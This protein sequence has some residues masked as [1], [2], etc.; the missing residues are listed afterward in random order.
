MIYKIKT[1][2][3]SS[4]VATIDDDFIKCIDYFKAHGIDLILDIEKTE[5]IKSDV[6]LKL[7]TP[8]SME[9]N[10][11]CVAYLYNRGTFQDISFGLAFNV[12]PTLRGIYLATD[13]VNDA[14]D[15]TWKSLCHEIVHTFF[16]KFRIPIL[17]PMDRML[18]N[19][20]WKPYYKDEE[21]KPDGWNAPDGNFA[22][23]WK[24]LAPYILE[25]KPVL[26]LR[27]IT[28]DGVQ[29]LGELI[30]NDFKCKTLEKPWKDNQSNISCVP[31]GLYDVKWS[32]FPRKLRYAY[33]LQNVFKR[34]GIF[35]H[36]GNFFFD[37]KG[38]I[39]LGMYYVDINKDGRKDIINSKVSIAK[40]EALMGKKPFKLK[41]I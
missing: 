41:I 39:L 12:S 23:A 22:E 31:K 3:H 15:F 16:Y 9:S 34:D 37:I 27:R 29:T 33:Q 6:L 26:T 36:D 17:D 11:D 25:T 8:P 1:Y 4:V 24:R 19:N 10:Y 32:F 5:V 38:C 14:V 7:M 2:I 13:R 20:V 28:D 21:L 40:L 30:Y 35:I 18:V